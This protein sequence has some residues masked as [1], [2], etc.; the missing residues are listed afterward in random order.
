MNADSL[1]QIL[2][3][4]SIVTLKKGEKKI[5]IIGRIQENQANHKI[6]DYAAC[7]YPEGFIQPD[8]IYLFQQEDIDRVFFVGMQESEEFAFRNYMEERL[9]EYHMI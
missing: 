3:L 5:M 8:E 2:P 9:R 6:Y 1:R 4:G 7:L